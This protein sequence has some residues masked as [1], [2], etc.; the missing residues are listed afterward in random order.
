MD[1]VYIY[2]LSDPRTLKIRYVG[3]TCNLKTRVYIHMYKPSGNMKEWIND[4]KA[5]GLK[6]IV[7]ILEETDY[8]G[9]NEAE[10]NWYAVFVKARSPILNIKVPDYTPEYTRR[11]KRLGAK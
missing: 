1:T 4:L 8:S 9:A 3:Q 6:P 5:N 2:S 7:T 10:G 11:F